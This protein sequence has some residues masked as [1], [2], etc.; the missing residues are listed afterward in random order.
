M[1]VPFAALSVIVLVSFGA[2]LAQD[3][4]AKKEL[5]RMEGTWHIVSGVEKGKPSSDYLVQNL[6]FVFKG[7]QLTFQGDELIMEKV[8]KIAIT[9][10]PATNPKCIDLKVEAGT[11]KDLLLEGIYECKG[12]EL[13]LCVSE[14]AGNRPLEFES[15]EGSKRVLFVL[16]RQKP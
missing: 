10:D 16:K 5:A 2:A 15:K 8:K 4:A 14:E 3:D 12:D 7:S 1:K 9:I 11:M 6:K 13:K